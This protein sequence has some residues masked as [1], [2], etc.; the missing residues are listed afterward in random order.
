M[1]SKFK[2]LTALGLG[3]PLTVCTHGGELVLFSVIN[4]VEREDG[5]NRSYLV[6]G[7]VNGGPR[8]VCIRTQ[9]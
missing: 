3:T 4:G 1:N 2:L 9:D 6:S 8:V 7:I 5:S